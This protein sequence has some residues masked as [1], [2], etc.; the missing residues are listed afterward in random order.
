MAWMAIW[1]ELAPATRAA[2]L[3]AAPTWAAPTPSG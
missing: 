1:R 2:L 3:M